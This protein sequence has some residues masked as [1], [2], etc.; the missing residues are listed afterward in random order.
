MVYLMRYP[1]LYR[2]ILFHGTV[3]GEGHTRLLIKVWSRKLLVSFHDMG[4][5]WYMQGYPILYVGVWEIYY[6]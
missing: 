3:S 1:I 2:T 6:I 5:F 4:N